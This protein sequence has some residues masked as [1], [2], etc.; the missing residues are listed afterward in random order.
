MITL[1]FTDISSS[2]TVLMYIFQLV[3]Y[4]YEHVTRND[5]SMEV[6]KLKTRV[7]IVTFTGTCFISGCI[8]F[9]LTLLRTIAIYDPFYRI[10]QKLFVSCLVAVVVIFVILVQMH[11]RWGYTIH[12]VLTAILA[13]CNILMSAAIIIV[14][15]KKRGDGQQERNHAAVT[16][17]IISVIYVIINFPDLLTFLVS[18]DDDK[19]AYFYKGF[20]NILLL[21]LSSTLNPIV[22]IFQKHQMRRY[23]KQKLYKLTFW[24]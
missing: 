1:N 21:C 22:Y 13:C 17:V 5:A 11:I 10:K 7:I 23:I 12:T 20:I 4:I 2:L 15:K 8:T 16:M 19:T 6:Q 18:D 24:C 9:S 3:F 14:L